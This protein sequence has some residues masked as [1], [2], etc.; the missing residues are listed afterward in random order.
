LQNFWN[1]KPVDVVLKDKEGMRF[2]I[3]FLSYIKETLTTEALREEF[4]MPLF[5]HC[6]KDDPLS[7]SF[8][9]SVEAAGLTNLSDPVEL[10]KLFLNF[11]QGR[12]WRATELPKLSGMACGLEFTSAYT[13]RLIAACNAIGFDTNARERDEYKFLKNTWFLLLAPQYQNQLSQ[14][15]EPVLANGSIQEFC[16]VLN[17]GIPAKVANVTAPNCFCPFCQADI[18]YVCDCETGRAVLGHGPGPGSLAAGTGKRKFNGP[19]ES[20]KGK[21]TMAGVP[22]PQAVRLAPDKLEQLKKEGM[23]FRECGEAYS[24]THWKTC[25]KKDQRR[26]SMVSTEQ[27]GVSGRDGP[28]IGMVLDMGLKDW[29]EEVMEEGGTGVIS[30]AMSPSDQRRAARFVVHLKISGL[31]VKNLNVDSMA[32]YSILS[33]DVVNSIYKKNVYQD[34]DWK[35]KLELENLPA[36]V[37]ASGGKIDLM[38]AMKLKVEWEG[39]L[40]Y[41]RFLVMETLPDDIIGLIGLDLMDSLGFVVGGQ[42]GILERGAS[43]KGT[44]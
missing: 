4:M 9:S 38:G 43:C 6:I 18:P 11:Y 27:R 30:T 1:S 32:D 17:N 19:N 20:R 44:N 21:A 39:K 26:N 7:G 15:M 14:I 16:D 13:A 3:G 37:N 22:G 8:N 40:I 24:L 28:M 23:C 35:N 34:T 42:S 2:V 10:K 29:D 33:K 5:R 25:P 12:D 36:L 41:A 31:L